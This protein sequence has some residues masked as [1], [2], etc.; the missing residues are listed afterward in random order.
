SFNS[1]VRGRRECVGKTGQECF[2][3]GSLTVCLASCKSLYC[4]NVRH[5]GW[6]P[7]GQGI[8]VDPA[9]Y[10]LAICDAQN[11]DT[12]DCHRFAARG[13]A[14]ELVF[15]SGLHL[16]TDD[17]LLALGDQVLDR[18]LSVGEGVKSS[19]DRS[20]STSKTWVHPHR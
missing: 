9:F 1:T 5:F 15:V 7:Q 2:S 19:F 3:S 17:H 8:P 16:P 13:D 18:P 12:C 14:P 11:G 20:L 6:L 10:D 4:S